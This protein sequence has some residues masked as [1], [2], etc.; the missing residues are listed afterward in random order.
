MVLLQFKHTLIVC[1]HKDDR[2]EKNLLA[3][4]HTTIERKFSFNGGVLI[5][6]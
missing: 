2:R 4:K 3:N 6:Q 1:I 5:R